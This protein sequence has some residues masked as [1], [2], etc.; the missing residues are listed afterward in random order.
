MRQNFLNDRGQNFA[1]LD[2]ALARHLEAG[3]SAT[4]VR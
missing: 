3:G 1:T 4:F 2:E